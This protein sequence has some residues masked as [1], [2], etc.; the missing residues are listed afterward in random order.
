MFLVVISGMVAWALAM[1]EAG[2]LQF[3][4]LE[5]QPPRSRLMTDFFDAKFGGGLV[6][7]RL[8]VPG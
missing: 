2:V 6:L 3:F 8:A 5:Q 4:Q 7:K 1:L